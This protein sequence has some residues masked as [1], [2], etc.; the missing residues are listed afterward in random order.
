MRSAIFQ[1]LV[2]ITVCALAACKPSHYPVANGQAGASDGLSHHRNFEGGG[3]TLRLELTP[4]ANL[5][6]QLD[7][8]SGSVLCAP[9]GYRAL[10]STLGLDAEDKVALMSW[11][12]LRTRHTGTLLADETASAAPLLV[13][14]ARVDIAER[15]RI[16]ALRA[17]DPESFEA[18]VALLSND[19]DARVLR[20]I[21]MRFRPRF[22][23]FW[24]STGLSAGTAYF[25]DL[26]GLLNDPFLLERSRAL[27][28]SPVSLQMRTR[29]SAY[30][31]W[32]NPKRK[33][34]GSLR[35]NSRQTLSSRLQRKVKRAM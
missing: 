34:L 4:Q 32:S 15:Q 30:T 31:S 27:H 7:C 24:N 23:R 20:E 26:A 14:G 17:R 22:M 5:T 29:L 21:I 16:A 6:Y 25:E 10:W 35:I 19:A 3:H 1:L 28:A 18:S 33:T 9:D 2:A 13:S 8:L 11:R 12:S